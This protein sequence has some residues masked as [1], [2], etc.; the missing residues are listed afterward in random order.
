[1][2]EATGDLF[3]R[4]FRRRLQGWEDLEFVTIEAPPDRRVFLK[5]WKPH[6]GTDRNPFSQ[7]EVEEYLMEV[8]AS[9]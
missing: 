5:I 8:P 1:M 6:V 3:R 9:P 2:N 7:W 4:P